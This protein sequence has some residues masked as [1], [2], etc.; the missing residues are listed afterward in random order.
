MKKLLL[1]LLTFFLMTTVAWGA[2]YTKWIDGTLKNPISQKVIEINDYMRIYKHEINFATQTLDAGDG[3]VAQIILLPKNTMVLKAWIRVVTACPASSTVDMGYGSDV[4][5]FGNGL[6]LDATGIVKTVY[7]GTEAW[8]AKEVTDGNEVVDDVTV[9]GVSLGDIAS[10]AYS[11]DVTDLSLFA[12]V[13]S[14]N[15]ITAQVGNFTSGTLTLATGT[16]VAFADKAPLMANPLLLST[17]DTIDIKAT[18]DTSD[19]NISTG[20][21]EINVLVMSTAASGFPQ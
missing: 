6:P 16:V 19:V 7:M 18:T 20:V 5:I 1:G 3:D 12:E 14:A 15:T 11:V 17:S 10:I 2:T 8:N 21:I 4:D 9:D 13:V